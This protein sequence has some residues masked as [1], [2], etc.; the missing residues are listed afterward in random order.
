MDKQDNVGTRPG[1][2][3]RPHEF[4]CSGARAWRQDVATAQDSGGAAAAAG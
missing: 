3:E 1:D 2:A 4:W